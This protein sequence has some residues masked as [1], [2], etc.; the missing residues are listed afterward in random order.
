MALHCPFKNLYIDFIEYIFQ[1][2]RKKPFFMLF[3][4][5][6]VKLG[7]GGRNFQRTAK[8]GGTPNPDGIKI[9]FPPKYVN[10]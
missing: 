10:W 2:P 8:K 1:K 5:G 7:L 3:G 6:N 9:N 4:G